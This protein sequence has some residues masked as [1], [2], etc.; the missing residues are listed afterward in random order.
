M[1]EST[2]FFAKHQYIAILSIVASIAQG[3]EYILAGDKDHTL[4][5]ALVAGLKEQHVGS[6]TQRLYL[7][8]VHKLSLTSS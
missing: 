5:R 2:N 6:V 8:L 1:L 3:R 4:L 7:A